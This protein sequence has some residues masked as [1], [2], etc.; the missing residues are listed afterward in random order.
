MRLA[1]IARKVKVKPAE[2]RSF[3]KDTFEI[4]LDK[5]PNIK[6][7]DSQVDAILEH[8]KIEEVV[9]EVV[10]EVI[11][12][13]EEEELEID[14]SIGTDLES[15]KEAIE[16]T[17][18]KIEI[19]KV[20]EK[21]VEETPEAEEVI[22]EV[23]IKEA[24]IEEVA[25][26]EEEEEV[27]EEE[28]AIEEEIIEEAV[29]E[30]QD[31]RKV[32]GI[33][34]ATEEELAELRAKK[35]DETSTEFQAVEVNENA[36]LIAAD[37]EKLE[38]FKVIGKIELE[39]DAET[40]KLLKEE[41]DLPSLEAIE[42]EISGLDGETDTSEFTELGE[43]ETDEKKEAIFAELDAQMASSGSDKIKKVVNKA[44]TASEVSENVEEEENSEYKD[45]RG[46]YHF[47][48]SQK[49][50]RR[51]SLSE[52]EGKKRARLGKEKKARHYQENVVKQ[53]APPKKKKEPSKKAV[54]NKEAKIKKAEAPKSLW[55]K[56]KNWIN[57]RN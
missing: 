26:E 38:G 5:D 53:A 3:I 29:T 19:P 55:G 45:S 23:Q 28:A 7:E 41:V 9:K 10:E 39:D 11:E 15:L 14:P 34:H 25:V 33:Q 42:D 18:E 51:K 22:E 27:V 17:I 44:V 36:E 4:E 13:V 52:S 16:E 47:S 56:F 31:D 43:G 32:V 54:A 48:S 30:V 37:I 21:V 6:I 57:D 1:Q 24:V 50:S 20:K 12:E 2:I 49:A 35:D 40:K 46:I 8:F